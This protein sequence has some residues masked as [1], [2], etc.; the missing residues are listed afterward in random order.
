MMKGPNRASDRV[1][2]RV[3]C[4]AWHVIGW[5]PK[6]DFISQS[7]YHDVTKWIVDSF[8]ILKCIT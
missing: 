2:E 6:V 5:G 7:M 1:W 4:F 8:K 3:G